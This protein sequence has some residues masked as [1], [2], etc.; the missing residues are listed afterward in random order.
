MR[1]QKEMNI[2]PDLGGQVHRFGSRK[3]HLKGKRVGNNLAL[4]GF[5]TGDTG[6][7][8]GDGKS[9]RGKEPPFRESDIQ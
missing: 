8:D 9:S 5:Q 4:K 7:A 2:F 1:G 6:H 3:I